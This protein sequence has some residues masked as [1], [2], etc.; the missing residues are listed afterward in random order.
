MNSAAGNVTMGPRLGE[1]MWFAKL[2]RRSL[3]DLDG[4]MA[5][6]RAKTLAIGTK[7]GASLKAPSMGTERVRVFHSVSCQRSAK[8]TGSPTGPDKPRER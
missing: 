6:I 2:I 7:A 1:A 3:N 5:R 8:D 4:D